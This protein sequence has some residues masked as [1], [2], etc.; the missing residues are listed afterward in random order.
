MVV[1]FVAM[2]VPLRHGRRA[3]DPVRERTGDD[4]ARLA[5]EAHRAAQVGIRSA[6]L[7]RAVAVLPLGDEGHH[8]MPRVGI[9]FGA[10]GAFEAGDMPRVLDHRE[11]HAEADAEIRDA[12]LPR[13]ADR[14]DL[15]LDA[16]LAEAA[17]HEDAVHAG[18]TVGAVALDRLGIDVV[19]VH[20]AAGM[21][22]GV[23]QRLRQRLVRLRQ[24]DVLADHRDVHR[25]LGMLQR[26]DEAV[27]R[28]Q[29][30]GRRRDLQLLADDRIEPFGMQ[31]AGNLVDRVGIE[32]GNHRVR[33]EVREQRDLAPVALA[34]A[35]GRRG[36]APRRAG[37]RSRATPSPS[38][39]W[40]S[41]S[42][43]RRPRCTGR[44]SGARSRRCR[45][46]A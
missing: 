31:R 4:V 38:A 12:V 41:S 42:S 19:D 5:A 20:L 32:R 24:I 17:G 37:C 44:A 25:V 27:P 14:G 22:A 43:R 30:R 34:D 2:P 26:L 11:L 21:D 16:A 46:R 3:V 9:E 40:A 23:R 36:T 7:D 18:K 8:R 6:P 39:A 33:R 10:V 15:A 45:G 1:H 29:V 35:D 28:R 13:V